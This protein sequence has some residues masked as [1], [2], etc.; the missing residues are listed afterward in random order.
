MRNKMINQLNIL[1]E[2]KNIICVDKPAK[3]LS[4]A[5][6]SSRKDILSE[7]K[8][9]I[10]IRDQK[11]SNVFLALVHRL[12]YLT[13]GLMVFAKRSKAASRL[14]EQ[15][16]EHK[17]NKYYLLVADVSKSNFD[18]CSNKSMS[19]YLYKDEKVQKVFVC[20]KNKQLAKFARL[21]FKFLK[22]IDGK[23]LFLVLLD[24][25][26]QHQIRVQF[27]NRKLY[28][29]GDDRYAKSKEALQDENLALHSLALDFEH[30]IS[31]EKINVITAVPRRGA[32][33]YFND[34]LEKLNF[35]ELFEEL[36]ELKE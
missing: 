16:R 18:F 25:G 10:R 35:D 34:Y 12:D 19:D 21:Y 22:V 4:Q 14:S 30:P 24:T 13:S 3:V 6:K 27:S 28:L 5:D 7:L 20:D 9:Y 17:I 26:R 29:Y 23:G 8:D 15:V 32:F 31:K 33:F 1:F 36:R 11:E 2:D